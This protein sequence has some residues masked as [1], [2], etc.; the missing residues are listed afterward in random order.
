MKTVSALVCVIVWLTVPAL[1]VQRGEH[2]GATAVH[3]DRGVDREHRDWFHRPA[4][5]HWRHR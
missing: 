4:W 3:R 2:P 1:A 5:F